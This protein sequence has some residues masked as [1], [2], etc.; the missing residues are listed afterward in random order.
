MHHPMATLKRIL[1]SKETMHITVRTDQTIVEPQPHIQPK[2]APT[3]HEYALSIIGLVMSVAGQPIVGLVLSIIALRQ[4]KQ[5]NRYN[6]YALLGMIFGIVF[7]AMG[8]LFILGYIIVSI[9]S[10]L[11]Y[12][13]PY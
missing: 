11:L 6:L 1:N 2:L 8:A 9:S 12:R 3:D 7:V 10:Q 13:L 4:S 5:A